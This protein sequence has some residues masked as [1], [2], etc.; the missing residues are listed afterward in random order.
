MAVIDANYK[1]VYENVGS[2]GS[3]SG[4]G[5]FAHLNLRR[6]TDGGHLKVPPPAPVPNSN[7]MMPYMFV[8]DDAFSLCLDLQK[9]YSHRELDHDQKVYNYRLSRPRRVVENSFGI[10]A[11]RVFRT[12][13]CLDPEKVVKITLAACVTHPRECRSQ[14]YRRPTLAD[15]ESDDHEMMPGGGKKGLGPF[16]MWRPEGLSIPPK[17]PKINKIL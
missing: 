10:L 5:L 13:I 1:F 9:P 8:K 7:T 14:A 16:M 3:L 6:A 15:W 2:Q 11:N 4:G 12:T 17:G